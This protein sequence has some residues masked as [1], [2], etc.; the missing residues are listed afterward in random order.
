MPPGKQKK[1]LKKLAEAVSAILGDQQK[2]KKLRKAEA[3]ER[4]IAKLEDKHRRM[5]KELEKGLLQGNAAEEEADRIASL[6]K[7]IKK[8]KKILAGMR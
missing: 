1:R 8:A 2:A 3:L 5:R 6:G 4:F 7:Q